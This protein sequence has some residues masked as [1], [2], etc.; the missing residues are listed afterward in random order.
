MDDVI[1]EDVKIEKKKKHDKNSKE[2]ETLKSR[3]KELEEK[4]LY[5]DAELINY[6]KRKDDEVS[7]MLKYANSDMIIPILTIVDDF[8][9]AI[10]LDDNILDDEV[11]KFLSGFKMIYTRLKKILD[12]F[13]VKEIDAL[14]KEFDPKYHQAVFTVKDDRGPNIVLEVLQKGYMYKDKVIR[15]AMVK[16]SE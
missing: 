16:V 13:E 10:S 2:I 8:E 3:I 15:P 12:D 5:K 9:R 7:N 11:S 1:M 6:R 4:I 14:N